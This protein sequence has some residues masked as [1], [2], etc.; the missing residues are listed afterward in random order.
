MIE[1][2]ETIF[3]IQY[4]KTKQAKNVKLTLIVGVHREKCVY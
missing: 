2:R 4:K 1:Q 3:I